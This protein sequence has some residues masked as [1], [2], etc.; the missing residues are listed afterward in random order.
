MIQNTGQV[1]LRPRSHAVENHQTALIDM[2]CARVVLPVY[3]DGMSLQYDTNVSSP[4]RM[5]FR[6]PR[7]HR[8]VFACAV[9]HSGILLDPQENQ[10]HV[11]A[12]ASIYRLLA[13][14]CRWATCSSPTGLS[15]CFEQDRKQTG[16]FKDPDKYS[17]VHRI[18]DPLTVTR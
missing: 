17:I 14:P 10:S 4:R 1:R 15:V 18:G 11:L 3:Y 16:R 2:S 9:R 6:F 12:F 8:F 13:T 5:I 7:G